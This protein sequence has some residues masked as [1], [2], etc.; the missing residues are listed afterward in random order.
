MTLVG[1]AMIGARERW[2]DT[3]IVLEE[4]ATY[5]LEASG[6]WVDGWIR[7]GAEG[8]DRWYLRP[9][10][11][12]RRV[13]DANWFALIATIDRREDLRAPAPLG[14]PWTAPATG[15]LVCYAND[16]PFMYRNNKGAIALRVSRP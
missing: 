1:T 5:V 4:G 16:A 10:R 15:T 14:K 11:G 9:V 7:C 6:E 12:L 13:R 8:Y 2:S 3:G